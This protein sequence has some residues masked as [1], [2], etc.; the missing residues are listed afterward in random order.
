MDFDSAGDIRFPHKFGDK[1]IR[2]GIDYYQPNSNWVRVGLRVLGRYDD[3]NDDWLQMDGNPNEWAVGYHG[4]S[5]EGTK[6][7]AQTRQF[8]VNGDRQKFNSSLDMNELSDKKGEPC[9][10]GAYFA[11]QIE[12]SEYGFATFTPEDHACVIQVCVPLIY[13]LEVNI[14]MQHISWTDYNG[15]RL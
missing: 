1:Q 2:G 6:A 15:K 4:S 14:C 7:I 12:I 3:G 5:E 11:D 10:N 9:G 8:L 13:L